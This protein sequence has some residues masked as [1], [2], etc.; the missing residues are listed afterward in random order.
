MQLVPHIVKHLQEFY[1]G[2]N[3]TASDLKAQL[4]D[5]TWQEA[6]TKVSN[7]NTIAVLVYHINYYVEATLKVLEGQPLNAHDNYS[8]NCPPIKSKVAWDD[9][10][11]KVFNDAVTFINL[12]EKLP[13]HLLWQDI[14]NPK[15]GNYYRN[16]Q[17]IIEHNYYHLGQ[18]VVLKKI[19]RR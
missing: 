16:I 6:T 14:A 18:I 4:K 2:S 7:L 19:I 11:S 12:L 13:E 5:I 1:E 10:M 3:W 17:G 15:Y 9:L 8:F